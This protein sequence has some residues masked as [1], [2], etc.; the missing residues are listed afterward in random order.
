VDWCFVRCIPRMRGQG[1]DGERLPHRVVCAII[2]QCLCLVFDLAGHLRD[3]VHS[4][5]FLA[6]V[7]GL[8]RL[9]WHSLH[10]F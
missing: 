2:V 1:L 4:Y 9:L 6:R 5:T 3:L 8:S 7:S 10:C